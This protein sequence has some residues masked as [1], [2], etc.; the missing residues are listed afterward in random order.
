[1]SRQTDIIFGKEDD[2][3]LDLFSALQPIA[4]AWALNR[5]EARTWVAVNRRLELLTGQ[6]QNTPTYEALRG[7]LNDWD[8]ILLKFPPQERLSQE[9][10]RA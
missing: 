10:R 1:M 2:T 6:T 9:A 7:T 8:P 4:D 5:E 3:I